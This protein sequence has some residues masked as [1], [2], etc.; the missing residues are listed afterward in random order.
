MMGRQVHAA[1]V[2]GGAA[3]LAGAVML[4][5]ARPD[6][7][8]LVLEK[9]PRTGRKLLATG[10]GTCN[11]TNLEAAPQRYHGEKAG[12]AQAAL[13]AFPPRAAMRFFES[14]G[15]SCRA[16]ANGRV[17]PLCE[18]AAA[19]LDCLRLELSARGVEERCGCPV[20]RIDRERAGGFV[21]QTPGG[22]VYAARV[23]VAAGGAAAP[24]LGG[25][26]DG[27]ALL[28]ALGH[29]RTPLFPTIVQLKTDTTF[30]RAVKG[31]R[32]EGTVSL[33]LEGERLAAETG[34]ILFT[35]YGLSGPAVMQISRFAGDW[36]RRRQGTMEA[37]LDLLPES[38][39][40]SLLPELW[41]RR[42]ILG[43]RLLEDFLTGLLQRRIGQTVLRAAG[44]GPL[45]R[46][47]ESLTDGELEDVARTL[48]GWRLPVTGTAGFGGAQATAGGIATDGFDP[49]TLES[50]LVPGLYA[51]GEVLDIDGDCGG[52]NLQ[53]AWASAHAATAAMAKG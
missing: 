44:I 22:P 11:L 24:S 45:S 3:G 5:R 49:R 41:E 23:L 6:W 43:D 52:F 21:L 50:R 16:R 10:S 29:A 32:A 12:F 34:E 14:M 46:R 33:W 19:V 9:A 4:S 13:A 25:S 7:R 30:V 27:Y 1:I 28:T 8:I 51:A 31:L 53:W 40:E 36:E 15:V 39:E 47:A 38:A 37:R 26:G 35:D 18:S 48:K 42:R 2:G 20:T 17:Y